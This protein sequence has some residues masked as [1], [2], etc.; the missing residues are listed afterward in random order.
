MSGKFPYF[1][2]LTMYSNSNNQ[3]TTSGTNNWLTNVKC[4]NCGKFD[5]KYPIF[6]SGMTP[7]PFCNCDEQQENK[8]QTIMGWKCPVCGRGNSP[9]KMTCDCIPK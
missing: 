4:P 2:K 3:V 1:K 6:S 7:V 5:A 9:Y 8:K